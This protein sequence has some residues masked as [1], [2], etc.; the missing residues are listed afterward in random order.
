MHE[1]FAQHKHYRKRGLRSTVPTMSQFAV[2]HLLLLPLGALVAVVW[3]NTAA[4]SYFRFSFSA[5]FIVNDVAM[6]IFYLAGD[7]ECRTPNS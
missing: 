5:Q 3:A 6:A 7:Q 2:E 4:G 1:D